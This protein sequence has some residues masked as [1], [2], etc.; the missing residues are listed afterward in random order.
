MQLARRRPGTEDLLSCSRIGRHITPRSAAS[1]AARAQG[2]GDSAA[3][4]RGRPGTYVRAG[5]SVAVVTPGR[6]PL[7]HDHDPSQTHTAD[8]TCCR[9]HR[10]RRIK[11]SIR[12][13]VA[14]GGLGAPIMT[15]LVRP[16]PSCGLLGGWVPV[17]GAARARRWAD[18][19]VLLRI[20]AARSW[21]RSPIPSA[22]P[23]VNG[24]ARE[25]RVAR[26]QVLFFWVIGS[27]QNLIK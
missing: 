7:C 1:V 22:S 5:S 4:A 23:P 25:H 24:A 21:V 19:R 12:A 17:H 20:Y 10:G 27:I 26:M 18:T 2:L 9:E 15:R 6:R 8:P 16:V 3:S 14:L 11:S 13:L